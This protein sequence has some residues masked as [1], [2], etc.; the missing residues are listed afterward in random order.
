MGLHPCSVKENFEKELSIVKDWLFKRSFCAV[1]EMGLDLHW[2]TSF[3]EQQKQAFIKQ[4]EWAFELKI[5]VVLHTRKATQEAIDLLREMG[6][7]RPTGVFHCFGGTLEEAKQ[8]MD[9]GFYMGI[10]GVVTFKNGGL[11]EIL[12]DIPLSSLVL[13][14]D[15]PYL[16]P[17]PFRGKRNESAFIRQIA[18]TIASIYKIEEEKVAK[19]TTANAK[20]IFPK[21]FGNEIDKSTVI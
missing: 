14:T 1:G 10:G 16:A 13:E 2:D 11:R 18:N 6:N 20:K 3:Y 4:C 21:V 9:M 5:P 12:A 7:R 17:V 19:V 15:S 8:I